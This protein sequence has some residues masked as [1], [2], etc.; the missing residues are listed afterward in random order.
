MGFLD[1]LLGRG[2]KAA[3]HEGHGHDG[4]SH[5]HEGH[6]HTVTEADLIGPPDAGM[7]DPASGPAAPPGVPPEEN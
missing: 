2:R 5:S 1:K 7:A 3:G 4:H 6:E